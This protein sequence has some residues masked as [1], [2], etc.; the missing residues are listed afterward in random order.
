M[1]TPIDYNHKDRFFSTIIEN[2]QIY[3]QNAFFDI[4][5]VMNDSN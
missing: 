3:F 5:A 1:K 4:E 2:T